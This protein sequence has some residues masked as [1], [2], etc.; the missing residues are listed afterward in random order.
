MPLL[1]WLTLAYLLSS[2]EQ[3]TAIMALLLENCC[4]HSYVFIYGLIFISLHTNV[5]FDSIFNKFV[6]QH[7]RAKVKV[8]VAVIRKILPLFW[9]SH[10]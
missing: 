7:Y 2:G 4:E 1:S 8:T 5:E 3:S 10:L 6:F 9:L